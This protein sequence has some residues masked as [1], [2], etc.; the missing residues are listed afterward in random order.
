MRSAWI[1]FARRQR[2]SHW[3][4]GEFLILD[5]KTGRSEMMTE[6]IP[7][8]SYTVLVIHNVWTSFTRCDM[9]WS[10]DV[11]LVNQK[12]A[13]IFSMHYN[14]VI[15]SIFHSRPVDIYVILQPSECRHAGL[16]TCNSSGYPQRG[17]FMHPTST[18]EQLTALSLIDYVG[19]PTLAYRHRCCYLPLLGLPVVRPLSS[20]S[21]LAYISR[22]AGPTQIYTSIGLLLRAALIARGRLV[23]FAS[24]FYFPPLDGRPL[25]DTSISF[26]RDLW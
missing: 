1:E 9:S 4:K 16:F 17:Q 10:R 2:C 14:R 21:R 11:R 12:R 24:S 3:R 5:L 15:L 23:S 26:L 20:E 25:T 22:G 19:P 13:T 18:A 7:K 8:K 6:G